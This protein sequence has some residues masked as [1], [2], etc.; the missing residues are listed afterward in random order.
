MLQ[1][2]TS[3]SSRIFPLS[4]SLHCTASQWNSLPRLCVFIGFFLISSAIKL[5]NELSRSVQKFKTWCRHTLSSGYK[6]KPPAS[7]NK[8][9]AASASF[10]RAE[11]GNTH[12]ECLKYQLKSLFEGSWRERQEESCWQTSLLSGGKREYDVPR[13]NIGA[14]RNRL[15]KN[16]LAQTY[17]REEPHADGDLS[18]PTNII[19]HRSVWYPPEETFVR[20][21][22][23][24]H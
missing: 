20:I 22:L 24:S 3:R 8:T 10:Q 13:K 11:K 18:P 15:V 23:Q 16:V 4:D 12:P 1:H 21:L 9:A 5:N 19:L 7:A 17:S 14:G 2:N 6:N